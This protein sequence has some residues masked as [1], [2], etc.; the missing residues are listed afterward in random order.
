M[1]AR[2]ALLAAFV[3]LAAV[4]AYAQ[5]KQD[6]L[7]LYRSGRYADAITVCLQELQETP[8]NVESHVVLGWSY[9]RLKKFPE[10]LAIGQKG[11]AISPNDPR[12]VQ[13]MAEAYVFLGKTDDALAN[14]QEYVALRP[15]G[16]RIA[17]VYW[18]MGE[19]YISLR[20][21]QNADIALSTALYYEQNNAAWWARL[22][23]VRE[24]ANDLQW[25]QEAY[26]R[27]LKLDPNL[28]D[29][30]RGKERVDKKLKG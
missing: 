11:L 27:S 17:R 5:E 21:Y 26:S 30:L 20:E 7:E 9:L 2:I 4:G 25:S 10:A 24:M 19:V 1:K 15:S 23:Y 28:D 3:L 29:A 13:I 16:D 18:L 12:L 8:K 14:L 22:G 6:A